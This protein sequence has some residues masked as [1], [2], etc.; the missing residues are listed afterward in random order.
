VELSLFTDLWLHLAI[1]VLLKRNEIEKNC[2]ERQERKLF[3]LHLFGI[4]LLLRSLGTGMMVA[5]ERFSC[6][7]RISE[8]ALP[9]GQ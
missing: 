2:F 6:S 4:F 8:M 7:F 1:T 3:L 9:S 5:F